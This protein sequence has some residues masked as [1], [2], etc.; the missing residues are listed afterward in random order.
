MGDRHFALIDPACTKEEAPSLAA[1]VTDCLVERGFVS[2]EQNEDCVYGGAGHPVI[3][4]CS[5][6]YDLAPREF[7]FWRLITSGVKV[8]DTFWWNW[9]GLNGLAKAECTNC[10]ATFDRE[11][12][13]VIIEAMGDLSDIVAPPAV[14]CPDCGKTKSIHDWITSPHLGFVYL[15][16]VFWNWPPLDSPGWRIHIPTLLSDVIDR[17]LIVTYG[18]F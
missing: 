5:G 15:A 3:P 16:I 9:Y 12:I 7:R 11:F 8:H 18:D 10:G 6:L 13:D 2:R 1:A 17:E 14:T 4:G